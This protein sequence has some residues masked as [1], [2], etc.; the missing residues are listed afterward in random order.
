MK[1]KTKHSKKFSVGVAGVGFMGENHA[2][3]VQ[4]LPGV[5]LAGIM[6]QDGPRA[7]VV[8][9]KYNTAAFTE[10]AP[11][12]NEADAV[13]IATPTSTH[14]D[15]ASQA[16]EAGKH[17]FIEKP[18]ASTAEEGEKLVAAAKEKGVV[19]A[20]GLIE[21][22]NPAFT[23][24]YNL[25]K[26][27]RPLII[28]IKRE[29]PLPQRITDASVVFDMMIHDLDLALKI[30]GTAPKEFKA[31]GKRVKTKMLDQA[32][33][34]IFFKNGIIANIEAS[35]VAEGKTRSLSANCER[36][37]IDADLLSKTVRQ[38]FMPDPSAPTIEPPKKIEHPVSPVDQITL[39]LKDFISAAK[40]GKEPEVTGR[41]ALDALRLAED[42]EGKILRK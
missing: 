11:L 10:F 7:E 28:N 5:R 30:A 38:K 6:D 24:A 2:R 37:N 19:L 1:P 23:V 13:I 33:V 14:F 17:V 16:I 4:P 40:R 20:C 32:F 15:L 41:D 29:S 31:K 9:T 39:E 8:S 35:R 27:D 34:N 25:I 26:K 18:L 22:F 12:L 21:R 36:S 42:I 3:L